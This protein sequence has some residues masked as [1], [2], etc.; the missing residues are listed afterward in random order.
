MKQHRLS[1]SKRLAKPLLFGTVIAG[2]AIAFINRHRFFEDVA[3][4]RAQE[5]ARNDAKR[6]EILE[7]RQRQIEQV[8]EW[9]R[10]G[11]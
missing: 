3:K 2:L 9:K 8:A 4:L 5:Q 6:I 1:A 10:G 11:G 7:R